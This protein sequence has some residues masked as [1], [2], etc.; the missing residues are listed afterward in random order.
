[1]LKAWLHRTTQQHSMSVFAILLLDFKACCPPWSRDPRYYG[2]Q[3]HK[4][5][6][7]AQLIAKGCSTLGEKRGETVQMELCSCWE[8]LA[9]GGE[10]VRCVVTSKRV[11]DVWK[12]RQPAASSSSWASAHLQTSYDT[13]QAPRLPA[14]WQSSIW[15]APLNI[16]LT[17]SS[18]FFRKYCILHTV[19]YGQRSL[20][21]PDM[22]A[23]CMSY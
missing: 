7:G 12:D 5:A 10:G 1:M 18:S 20:T 23:A 8:A 22:T 14:S 11:K 19:K 13:W 15:M 16:D 4:P 9:R 17:P 2:D 21:L 6:A 3:R